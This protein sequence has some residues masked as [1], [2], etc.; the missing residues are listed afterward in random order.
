MRQRGQAVLQ[1]QATDADLAVRAG[2]GDLEAFEALYR[3]HVEAAWRMALAI[4]PNPDDAAD[5]VS[6][7]FIRVF[8]ALPD[9]L[10]AADYFLPY[11]LAAVRNAAIDVLRRGGRQ[12]ATDPREQFDWSIL[13]S[14][15]AEM[16]VAGADAA[17]VARAFRSL[18]ERWRSVLWL[19][20][21]EGIPAREVAGL[22][23]VS[24]N[25]VAQLAVR[26]RAGL[27]QR[28][29]QAHLRHAEVRAYCRDTVG[30]LGAYA[31]GGLAPR[32]VA[33]VDQHLAGCETCRSRLAQL[34]DVAPGLRR[35]VLPL[36]AGLAAL[37][38]GKWQLATGASGSAAAT[39]TATST[40]GAASSG[41]TGAS[42]AAAT[43]TGAGAA[44]A[45]VGIGLGA[46]VIALPAPF[47]TSFASVA[48]F[49]ASIV[50]VG[51]VD[52]HLD[53]RRSAPPAAISASP[54]TFRAAASPGAGPL[55]PVEDLVAALVAEGTRAAADLTAIAESVG[56]LSAALPQISAPDAG[57]LE[58]IARGEVNVDLSSVAVNAD[59]NHIAGMCPS[60]RVLGVEI[61]CLL[62]R[63]AENA[64]PLAEAE[65]LAAE[66][67]KAAARA[68][69]GA[70]D[71]AQN[72]V[73][74]AV[75]A[76][77]ERVP[78]GSPGG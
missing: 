40:G 61:G 23:G 73:A 12:R 18:P 67:A 27:R 62:N 36:P 19:T 47:V 31:A 70:A 66:A 30:R 76:G 6:D 14:E 69:Q 11:L 49:M 4:T 15:P 17:L 21:V 33:K 50:G 37:V 60:V 56:G 8:Q 29:L 32:D 54:S 1:D 35:A 78:T 72:I 45:P 52:H 42:A 25:G 43:A 10:Q 71:T 57:D 46:A 64:V 63:P 55:E 75:E 2:S 53:G 74:E 44:A 51:V 24:A 65:A 38:L 22:L 5:A 39:A 3:R 34:E 16:M 9:R 7:A 77:Q 20:E 26:A 59:L 58:G 28:Y 68:Q 41:S 48:L 13:G